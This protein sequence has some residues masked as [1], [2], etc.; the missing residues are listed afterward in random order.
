M[1]KIAIIGS[2]PPPYGGISVHIQRLEQ[3]LEAE[4]HKPV[5]FKGGSVKKWL[6]KYFLREKFD[7]IHFHD[8][9]WVNRVLI[10]LLGWVGLPVILTV[11][12]DSLKNQLN[13]GNW[14]K[15]LL[16][17]FALKQ[18]DFIIAVKKEI[19]DLLLTLGV[20]PSKVAVVNAYLP[21]V[22]ISTTFF[23][24]IDSFMKSHSHLVVANGFKVIPL[25]EN[26]DLYGIE[27][28]IRLCAK[29][30][31]EFPQIGCL[32]FLAEKGNQKHF[33]RLKKKVSEL[34]INDSF[35]FVLG[36]EFSPILPKSTLFLR[37]TYED[38]FGISVSEALYFGI[39]AIAS[40]V[41][42]REK[43]SIIFKSGDID[44]LYKKVQ[45]VLHNYKKVERSIE[46]IGP[47]GA[48]GQLLGIYKTVCGYS[49]L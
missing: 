29:L 11:H 41:C 16:L 21:P 13:E 34:G 5:V 17:S 10:G 43:G 22:S 28:T 20:K 26:T 14:I 15:K 36:Q 49:E 46:K 37:P 40:N 47:V 2:Y 18:I 25:S 8:I 33:G 35:L 30:M 44:D 4:K 32:F 24:K 23:Q 31:K 38:G 42:D 6:L 1:L 27:L 7:I 45:Y 48:Y 9:L 19:Y 39:P 3:L 12:G